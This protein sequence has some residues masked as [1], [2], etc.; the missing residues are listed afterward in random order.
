MYFSLMMKLKY[1]AIEAN[2]V[3]SIPETQII[4]AKALT[5]ICLLLS[6]YG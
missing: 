6:G 1:E 5:G 4:L 2:W 3:N